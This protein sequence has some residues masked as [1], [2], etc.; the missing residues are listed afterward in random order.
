MVDSTESSRD[1]RASRVSH[2]GLIIVGFLALI[3]TINAALDSNWVG[4]GDSRRCGGPV[5]RPS[6]LS[7]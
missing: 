1:K 2:W 5:L 3:L 6:G 4:R 7:S